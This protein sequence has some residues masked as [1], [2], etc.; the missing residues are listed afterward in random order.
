MYLLS[1]TRYYSRS[2]RAAGC[3]EIVRMLFSSR[4]LFP[5]KHQN[6]CRKLAVYDSIF[7]RVRISEILENAF[8]GFLVGYGGGRVVRA[9]VERGSERVF[10][11][12][13]E[14]NVPAGD[15]LL[16]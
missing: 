13:Q 12:V 8:D 9:F 4:H 2:D 15:T 14:R 10:T 7:K 1:T 5:T 16:S 11:S 6:L 3:S